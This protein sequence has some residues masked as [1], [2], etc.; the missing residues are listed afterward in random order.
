MSGTLDNPSPDLNN[1]EFLNLTSR[2][3]AFAKD[4]RTPSSF[5][6]LYNQRAE[7]YDN[8]KIKGSTDTLNVLI[9]F[10]SAPNMSALALVLTFSRQRYSRPF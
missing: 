2:P 9:L 10:V 8:E 3:R 5:W 7:A 1:P 4:E 6:E